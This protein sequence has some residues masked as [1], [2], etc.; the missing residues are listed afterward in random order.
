MA[1]PQG[2]RLQNVN[3]PPCAEFHS[4]AFNCQHE[5]PAVIHAT[6]DLYYFGTCAAPRP[7]LAL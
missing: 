7:A 2:D 5:T 6:N 1:D 4:K 3:L